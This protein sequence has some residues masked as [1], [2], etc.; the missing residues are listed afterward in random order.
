[1]SQRVGGNAARKAATAHPEHVLHSSLT[2]RM[3]RDP[4]QRLYTNAQVGGA[5]VACSD[6]DVALVVRARRRSAMLAQAISRTSATTTMIVCR[7]LGP[8]TPARARARRSISW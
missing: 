6:R 5:P 3:A 8:A 2:L 4:E 7:A 1:M